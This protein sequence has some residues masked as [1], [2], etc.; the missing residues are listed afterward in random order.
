MSFVQG[1]EKLGMK[2]LLILPVLLAVVVGVE[3]EQAYAGGE[4]YQNRAN[5][6]WLQIYMTIAIIVGIITTASII[7]YKFM[8][9]KLSI[10]K[11]TSDMRRSKV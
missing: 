8:K 1:L 11:K 2:L 7:T 3:I 5:A 10:Y 6:Y 4:A 9:G